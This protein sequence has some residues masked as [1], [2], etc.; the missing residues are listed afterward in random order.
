MT[1]TLKHCDRALLDFKFSGDRNVRI[2]REYKNGAFLP[3][4]FHGE[5]DET[6]LFRWLSL[7]TIPANRAYVQNFLA[8]MG[9]NVN[10]IEGIIRLCRGLSVNDVHWVAEA[11]FNGTFAQVNLFENPFSTVLAR[12]A[13]SGQGSYG[14]IK[15]RSSP[16]FTTNGVLAKCWRRVGG[17]IILYKSGTEGAANTGNEPYSEFYAAQVAHAMGFDAVTYGLTRFGGRLCSTCE[18]FTDI[19][20]AFVPAGRLINEKAV[21][22]IEAAFTAY[23][24]KFIKSFQGMLLLDA[25]ICNEDRHLGNF[26][27]LVQN[28]VN[29]II[30]PAPLFDHGYSLFHFAMGEDISHLEHYAQILRPVLYNDFMAD[31]V[32]TAAEQFISALRRLLSFRFTP[33]PR[34]NLPA[35]RIH[36]IERFIQFRARELVAG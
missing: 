19:N 29:R 15:W 5:A 6:K 17:K 32:R 12:M 3:V 11:G 9:L 14:G 4:E 25:L 33:H 2:L 7:R 30:A 18:A 24:K 35:S 10:D 8:R 13:F 26:G 16:E 20:T 34:H 27:F 31:C 1:Y 22:S 28:R 21:E 36:A 23:G